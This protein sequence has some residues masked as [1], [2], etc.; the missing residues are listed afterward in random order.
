MPPARLGQLLTSREMAE[1]EALYRLEP[2]GDLRSDYAMAQ[3]CA[4]MANLAQGLAGGKK[5]KASTPE[6]FMPF[7]VERKP[8][9]SGGST[10]AEIR[11]LMS[12]LKGV[13]ET[14]VKKP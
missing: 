10:S 4:L 1:Y 12:G 3:V 7:V 5:S 14:R 8:V 2:W 11:S 6:D 13:K 9:K